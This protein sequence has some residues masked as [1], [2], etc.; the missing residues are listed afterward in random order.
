MLI[1]ELK[2]ANMDALRNKDAVARAILSVLINKYM[3]L[4][5]N[6]R[7]KGEQTTDADVVGLIQKTMK[8]LGEER[9]NYLKVNN[10]ERADNIAGQAKVLEKFLPSMLSEDKI[11]EIINGLEDKSIPAVMKH[12]KENYAGQVDMGLVN[13]IARGQ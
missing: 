3:L 11:R 2:K 6:K 10:Q 7:E 4:D 12:F 8:E 13:R 1:D 9:E 5:I